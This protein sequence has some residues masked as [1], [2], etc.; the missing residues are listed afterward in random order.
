[1]MNPEKANGPFDLSALDI[2]GKK[3][4]NKKLLGTM[5]DETGFKRITE[6]IA[7]LPKQY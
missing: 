1:M 6:L 7:P 5:K 3:C 4:P 2:P